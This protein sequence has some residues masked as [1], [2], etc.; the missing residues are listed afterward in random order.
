MYNSWPKITFLSTALFSPALLSDNPKI[1]PNSTTF[2]LVNI[3]TM[4]EPN[5]LNLKELEFSETMLKVLEFLPKYGDITYLLT[6][7][8][9]KIPTSLG[10]NSEIETIMNCLPTLE[11]SPTE[12]WNSVI[13]SMTRKL[14][15]LTKTL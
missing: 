12:D 7:L 6:D 2:L 5:F 4:K 15:N 11:T 8:K 13:K 14:P 1:G 9:N 10:E 3:W